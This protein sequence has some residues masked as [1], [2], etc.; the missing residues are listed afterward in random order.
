MLEQFSNEFME[1]YPL[2]N[3][4][5]AD[6]QNFSKERRKAFVAAATLN[7]PDAIVI[8]HDAFQRIGVKQET[9]DPIRDEILADLEEELAE[10]AKDSG[11]RV[12]RGQLQQQIEAVTQRFDSIVAAGKKDGVVDFEDMGVDMIFA[13]EAHVYRKLDFHTAQSIRALT[14]TARAGRLICTSRR[15]TWSGSGRAR[16]WCL[17]RAPP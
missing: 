13:D 15:A 11:A 16:R 7:A 3:I 6:D 17:P 10:A 14:P 1:L 4:M 12:R 9:T 5:V 2:A 8:T